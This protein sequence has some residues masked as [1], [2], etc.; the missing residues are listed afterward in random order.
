MFIYMKYTVRNKVCYISCIP[1]HNW[2]T[3]AHLCTK[4]NN[5]AARTMVYTQYI[6]N[7]KIWL[8]AAKGH[9]AQHTVKHSGR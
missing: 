6:S 4:R 8:A 7:V 5:P 9:I 3:V 2:F 1:I